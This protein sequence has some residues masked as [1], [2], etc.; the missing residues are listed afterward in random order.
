MFQNWTKGLIILDWCA[1]AIYEICF[2]WEGSNC[3]SDIPIQ[4]EI[5]PNTIC[6]FVTIP[7]LLGDMRTGGELN[8]KWGISTPSVH[9]ILL[10]VTLRNNLLPF[11]MRLQCIEERAERQSQWMK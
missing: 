5:S 6:L 9:L 4:D 7:S 10:K 8:W 3:H 2:D 1:V 11:G